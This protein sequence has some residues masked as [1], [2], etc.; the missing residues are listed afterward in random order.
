MRQH[1]LTAAE[2]TQLAGMRLSLEDICNGRF[3]DAH[4]R[5]VQALFDVWNSRLGHKIF[6]F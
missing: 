2:H 4:E 5:A 3:G 1:I 6:G